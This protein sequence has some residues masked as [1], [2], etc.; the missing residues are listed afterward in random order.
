MEMVNS[1]SNAAMRKLGQTYN[2]V[3]I[4]ILLAM[5]GSWVAFPASA[6][7][8]AGWFWG[9]V[10]AQFAILFAFMYYKRQELFYLFTFITGVTLVPV[11]DRYITAGAGFVVVQAFTTTAIITGG[12]TMYAL[13]TKKNFLGLGTLLFWILVGVV[14][15]GIINIFIASSMLSMIMAVVTAILFSFFI[16]HDTQQVIHTDIT[17]LDAAMGMYLNILNMFMSILQL[18]GLDPR[19]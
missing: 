9:V 5:F 2:Y 11:L 7:L 18:F 8:I 6:S 17:P 16:I 15:I 19:D 13:T 3:F 14:V 12:L 10:I 4:G 1:G